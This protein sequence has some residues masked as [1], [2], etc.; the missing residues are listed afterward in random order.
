M[1]MLHPT[2]SERAAVQAEA[3]ADYLEESAYSAAQTAALLV[4]ALR[5]AQRAAR[6]VERAKAVELLLREAIADAARP[7]DRLTL[8]ASFTERR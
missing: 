3:K 6:N 5:T 4:D 7:A 8:V 1:A 2:A